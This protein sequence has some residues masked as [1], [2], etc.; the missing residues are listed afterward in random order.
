MHRSY[1]LL[2]YAPDKSLMVIYICTEDLLNIILKF[3][4]NCPI[5]KVD[6]QGCSLKRMEP[7]L[8]Y[9]AFLFTY[10]VLWELKIIP[11]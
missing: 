11:V 4:V 3:C 10:I 6:V 7:I 9:A 5:Y 8:F 1:I 2:Y